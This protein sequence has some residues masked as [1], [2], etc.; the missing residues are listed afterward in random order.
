L[1]ESGIMGDPLA[2]TAEKGEMIFNQIKSYL[3]DMVNN[4]CI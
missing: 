2:A 4:F 3:V 1:T